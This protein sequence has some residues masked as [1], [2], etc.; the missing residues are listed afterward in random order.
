MERDGYFDYSVNL[1]NLDGSRKEDWSY[2]GENFAN[3][4]HR[5]MK[6][7]EISLSGKYRS[8]IEMQ[9]SVNSGIPNLFGVK[10]NSCDFK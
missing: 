2:F 3:Y 6:R 7:E 8:I 5:F 9:H 1:N 4:N 10:V